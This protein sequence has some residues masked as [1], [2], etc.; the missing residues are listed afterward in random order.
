VGNSV[1]DFPVHS[2]ECE[3]SLHAEAR[4]S[5]PQKSKTWLLCDCFK[6]FSLDAVLEPD[7]GLQNRIEKGPWGAS[8]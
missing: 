5:S 7:Q 8:E 4:A 2:R 1:Q 3:C 6:R